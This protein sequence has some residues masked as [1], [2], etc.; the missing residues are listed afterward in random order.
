MNTALIGVIFPLYFHP[1]RLLKVFIFI[2]Q[3]HR[4]EMI[5]CYIIWEVKV[6]FFLWFFARWIIWTGCGT[7]VDVCPH[8]SCVWKGDVPWEQLFNLSVPGHSKQWGTGPRKRA[9]TSQNS[10]PETQSWQV[11]QGQ[12]VHEEKREKTQKAPGLQHNM[13]GPALLGSWFTL[14]VINREI[15]AP[16][17]SCLNRYRDI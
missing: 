9:S 7:R 3:L 8:S 5:P 11:L 12:S 16:A 14:Q 6:L 13:A 17:V 2:K 1:L 10:V 4:Q 15:L